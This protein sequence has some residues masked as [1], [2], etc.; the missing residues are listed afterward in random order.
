MSSSLSRQERIRVEGSIISKEMP[1]FALIQTNAEDYFEGWKTTSTGNRYKL[2]LLLPE[3]YPDSIPLLYVVSPHTLKRHGQTPIN[4]LGGNHDFHTN[5][6]G[7]N[8]C[9]SICHFTKEA[10]DASRTSVQVLAM[11]IL[12]LECHSLHLITG[13]T[14]AEIA[15]ELEKRKV[16][17]QQH[18][19]KKRHFGGTELQRIQYASSYLENLAKKDIHMK[20][21]C[22]NFP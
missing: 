18:D 1:Q 7:P 2:K 3:H 20:Y 9:V 4:S 6:N 13:K 11:G 5:R 15:E 21:Y 8:G 17:T 12:W 19:N 22:N 16:N 10:W 14:I